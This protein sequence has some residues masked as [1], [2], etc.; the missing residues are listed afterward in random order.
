MT[1]GLSVAYLHSLKQVVKL[2]I[3]LF[4]LESVRDQITVWNAK[5]PEK[6]FV[7]TRV[8]FILDLNF[9]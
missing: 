2:K 8:S 6:R 7:G 9:A 1:L 3:N 5:L 4:L